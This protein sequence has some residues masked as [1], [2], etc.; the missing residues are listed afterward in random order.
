MISRVKPTSD[1]LL[2]DSDR[3]IERLEFQH[4]AWGEVS[5]AGWRRAGF[6][7]GTSILD[8]GCGPGLATREL[9]FLT[10]PEGRVHAM[11]PSAKFLARVNEI[12]KALGNVEAHQADAYQTLLADSCIDHVHARWLFCFLDR[13]EDAAAEMARVL[14]PGGSVLILDYFNYQAFSLAPRSAAMEVVVE[15]IRKYWLASH[16]S[17]DIQGVM[18]GLLSRAGLNVESIDNVSRVVTPDTPL[19]QW[20]RRFLVDYLPQLEADGLLD[21]AAIEEFWKDW[22]TAENTPGSYLFLPPMIEVIARK[23]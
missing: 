16:G 15:A 21:S 22:Q 5:R 13:P 7:S 17:L 18:P 2:G 12:A 20:P 10:G 9:A 6:G 14:K 1:Y 3:E 4:H 19:W 23:P 8:L 11:D